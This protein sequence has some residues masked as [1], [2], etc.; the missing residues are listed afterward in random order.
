M[1]KPEG[2]WIQQKEQNHA[3]SHQVHVDQEEYAAVIKT[4]AGSHA[5]KVIDD[6]CDRG[7]DRKDDK[8]IGPVVRKVREPDGDSETDQ[9][10]QGSAKQGA[11]TRIEKRMNHKPDF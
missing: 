4:P 5:A 1:G 6:S 3:E 11:L 7:K 9:N 2:V 10:Q 8:R